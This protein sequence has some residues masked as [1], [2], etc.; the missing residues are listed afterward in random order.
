MG[1]SYP[2]TKP[3]RFFNLDS[4]K[5][6]RDID[7]LNAQLGPKYEMQA[8]DMGHYVMITGRRPLHLIQGGKA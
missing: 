8:H 2:P 7:M 5:Y 3:R 1:S 6:V 4:K